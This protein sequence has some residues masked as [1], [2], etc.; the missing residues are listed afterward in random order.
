[1][2]KLVVFVVLFGTMLAIAQ[3]FP[4]GDF[5]FPDEFDIIKNRDL[6]DEDV[7]SSVANGTDTS[8]RS[9]FG[10]K[11]RDGFILKDSHCVRRSKK[12]RKMQ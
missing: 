9:L 7:S 11:C 4:G 5:I 8:L 12:F 2:H 1:M 3:C 6:I 10:I